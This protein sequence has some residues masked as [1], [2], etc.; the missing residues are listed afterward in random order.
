[1]Q[2][3]RTD[4]EDDAVPR[5]EE[6]QTEAALRTSIQ[7]ALDCLLGDVARLVVPIVVV[8]ESRWTS[9]HA[10]LL[11]GEGDLKIGE[12]GEGATGE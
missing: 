10:D 6:G 9:T 12:L 11:V 5:R 1:M 7:P 2:D 4:H 3:Q 8:G